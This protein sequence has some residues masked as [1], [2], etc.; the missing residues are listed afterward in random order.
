MKY[1][2]RKRVIGKVP[3][4]EITE[5]QYAEFEIARSKLLNAFGVEEK[6]E[7]VIV[8]YLEFEKQMLAAAADNMVRRPVDYSDIFNVRLGMNIRLINLLTAI[9]MYVDQLNQNVQKCIPSDVDVKE[10]VANLFSTE[11]DGNID[12]RFMEALRN[13]VQHRGFPVHLT[14]QGMKWT[15]MGDDGLLE[16]TMELSSQHSN[17]KEDDKFKKKVLLEMDDKI[18]LKAATRHYVESISNVHESVRSMITESVMSARELIEDAHSQYAT[19]YTDS[20]VGLSA[21]KCSDD[22][23]EVAAVSLLLDWDDIRVTL[24][25]RNSHLANLAKRYVTSSIKANNK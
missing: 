4:I 10:K 5:G 16:F 25:R 11:Y 3:E 13:Y 22:G 12:Y 20:L 1:T 23:R 17:L 8:S 9:R 21:C 14:Q 6:Y 18:D 24:Q 15:S 2:L 19:V 7:V